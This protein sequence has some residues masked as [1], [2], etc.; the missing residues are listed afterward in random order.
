[1][2]LMK[3]NQQRSRN[4]AQHN[5]RQSVNR[6]A[7]TLIECMSHECEHCHALKWS[8]EAPGMCCLNGRA[9]L[10][11]LGDTPEILKSLLLGQ[12]ID[13]AHFLLNIRKYDSAIQMISLGCT[14][15]VY[16]SD[17]MPT[18]KV[19]GQVY[20]RIGSMLPLPN[21]ELQFL[22]IYFMGDALVEAERRRCMCHGRFEARHYTADQGD[23]PQNK[24]LCDKL[25]NC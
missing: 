18:F 12:S 21:E 5:E 15:Q 24:Q 22:Q 14:E 9:Q 16:L 2:T 10:L 23:A 8:S 6:K 17:F 25:Q 13:S 11:P 7:T 19:Q 20:H 4:K 1:M 3:P